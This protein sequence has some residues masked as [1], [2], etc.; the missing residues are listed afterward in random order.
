MLWTWETDGRRAAAAAAARTV[1]PP[2]LLGR[3][4]E[5]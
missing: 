2:D 4:G 5:E 1:F 3:S